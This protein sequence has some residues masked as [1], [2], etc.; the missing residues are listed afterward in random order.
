MNTYSDAASAQS[1]ENRPNRADVAA[2]VLVR[3][4]RVFVQTGHVFV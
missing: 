1:H 4:V 3:T 2:L